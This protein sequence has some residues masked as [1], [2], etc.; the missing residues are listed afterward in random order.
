DPLRAQ[1]RSEVAKSIQASA[2]SQEASQTMC[3]FYKEHQQP[4]ASR[5]LAQYVSLALS[6]TGPPFTPRSRDSETPKPKPGETVQ[7]KETQL[8]PRSE[9]HTSELQSPCNLVCR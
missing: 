6:L 7:M 2:E 8:P 1:I 9:E 4:D 3:E 5:E